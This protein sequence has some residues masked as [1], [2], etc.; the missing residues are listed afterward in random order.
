MIYAIIL[1]MAD[2]KQLVFIDDSG[3]PGFKVSSSSH[4]IIAAVIVLDE[5]TVSAISAAIDEFRKS[6][7]W[8][9][10]DEF[11]FSKTN[12][13]TIVKLLEIV[14]GYKFKIYA[15]VIDKSKMSG[16][17]EIIDKDSLYNA[18]IKDTLVKIRLSNGPRITIDGKAGKKYIQNT[19]TYLRKN[20]KENGVEKCQINFVDSRKNN[21]IQ[22][23]DIVAG[24]IARSYQKTND[25][26]KYIGLLEN[27]IKKI[28]EIK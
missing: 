2:K 14:A 26:K 3:D 9:E 16:L 27:K 23:A 8:D 10:L 28:H 17:S 22:L 24:S 25:A 7:K 13:H 19:R 12:K 1:D 18:T 20:L 15:T 4:F 11:K 6:L 5:E 21:L